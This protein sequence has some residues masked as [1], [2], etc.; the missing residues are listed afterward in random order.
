MAQISRHKLNPQKNDQIINNFVSTLRELSTDE[1]AYEFL[2]SLFTPTEIV[3]LSK[4]LSAAYLL[5]KGNTQRQVAAT[6]HLSPATVNH[7]NQ[8]FKDQSTELQKILDKLI[9]RQNIANTLDK[10]D[11]AVDTILPPKGNWKSH[12]QR[13]SA[14]KQK[15]QNQF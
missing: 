12:F 10:I 5:R 15:L 14:K 2:S 3:M 4:R 1:K 7:V 8:M 11:I 6:L 13:L 9:K